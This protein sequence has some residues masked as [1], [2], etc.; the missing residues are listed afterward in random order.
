MSSPATRTLLIG[1]GNRDK[2]A[3]L[4]TLLA[5]SV[6]RVVG[7]EDL[8]LIPEPEED[9]ATFEANAL[10]KSRY[11][12]SH[13]GLPCVADDSGL[14]V[15]A[16]RGAPGVYSARYAGPGCSYADNNRKLLRELED[17]PEAARTARFVCCAAYV[18]TGGIEHVERGVV[19]GRIAL[20]PRGHNGFGY[21]PLFIPQGYHETFGE[22]PPEAKHRVSHRGQAFRKMKFYLLNHALTLDPPAPM[23]T[24]PIT[25]ANIRR[26]ADA[27]HEGQIVCHPTE[28]VYGLGADPM[29]VAA[30]D[31]LFAVKER[32][33]RNPVLLI[34]GEEAQ[35][36][37]IA[38]LTDR[39]RRYAEK[40]WPGP[41]SLLLP[42][43]VDA[44]KALLGGDGRVCVRWTASPAAQQLACAFGGAIVSTSANRSGQLPVRRVQELDLAGVAMAL[45]AGELPDSAPST[46]LDPETG[47]ILRAGAVPAEVLER[48]TCSFP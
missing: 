13:Y 36:S 47:R 9:Q 38:K 17:V 14:E 43:A 23:Q 37:R 31:R 11:Y 24:L 42:P 22:L 25:H 35:L 30:L 19:E 16:L 7:L 18:D 8:D 29:S 41:L 44:P 39:A 40:F 27:L 46:V 10:L 15:D 1:T 20:K 32:E 45:D 4:K 33:A 48:V 21:D 26:A 6:W 2:A 12:S 3:E 5:D 34:I 28:T